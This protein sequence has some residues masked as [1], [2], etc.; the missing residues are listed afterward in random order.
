MSSTCP[1]R[2]NPNGDV[3]SELNQRAKMW[4]IRKRNVEQSIRPPAYI[5]IENENGYILPK[6][7]MTFGEIYDKFK[8]GPMLKNVTITQGGNY[9]L[10][11][12]ME[13]EIQCHDR[14]SFAT[15]EEEFLTVGMEITC[16]FGYAIGKPGYSQNI[17]MKNFMVCGYEF[18]TTDKGYWVAKFKAVSAA[19]AI[20]SLDVTVAPLEGTKGKE[21]LIDG[22]PYKVQGLSEI[23]LYH[24]QNNGKTALDSADQV[25]YEID[26]EMTKGDLA[27]F[28]LN[29]LN[30]KGGTG[31]MG[32]LGRM[33]KNVF[34]GKTQQA[35]YTLE[36][37]VNLFNRTMKG[38]YT[39]AM[40]GNRSAADKFINLE[41]KFD[42]VLSFAYYDEHILSAD[43]RGVLL[44]MYADYRFKGT[45]KNFEDN[46][47]KLIS[48]T[49]AAGSTTETING[50]KFIK[51][52]LKHILVSLD[53]I[54]EAMAAEMP[55]KSESESNS[56]R[57]VDE[58]NL[59]LNNFFNKIFSAIR[60]ASGGAISLRLS[61]HPNVHAMP[62][63]D[64]QY[65][66]YV[67][68]E[69]NGKQ[70]SMDCIVFNP[71]DGD[72]IIKGAALSSGAGGQD[73]Q[74]AMF[75]TA[76]SGEAP[77]K[78][79]GEDTSD[80]KDKYNEAIDSDNV[81]AMMKK[82]VESGYGDEH[83]HSLKEFNNTMRRGPDK[84]VNSVS[85]FPYPG[86][87]LDID[88]EGVYGI[89]PMCGVMTTHFPGSY[90][91]NDI[92]FYV[93]SVTHK[94]DAGNSS[95]DTSFETQMAYHNDVKYIRFPQLTEAEAVEYSTEA[96]GD[97]TGFGSVIIQDT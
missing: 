1:F 92:Y 10:T 5:Q 89:N 8:P 20:L 7:E 80:K 65:S 2:S 38:T 75:A 78:A 91:D 25:E 40:Q 59:K 46:M 34:D 90:V 26:D 18:N 76:K 4:S 27:I 11:I 43:P 17:N 50:V 47:K 15:I 30:R 51:Q 16:R 74:G 81:D 52:N 73:Y 21:F 13:A 32:T 79:K 84:G 70:D 14:D 72:G 86:M 68:D 62:E 64:D 29:Q 97:T 35:Y 56:A 93:K 57:K 87:T 39:T 88:I 69:N 77:R 53:T 94:F 9:G 60:D 67:F 83:L 45:G 33:A 85:Q 31:I 12:E 61:Q 54:F 3:V 42:D 48:K 55:E 71:I 23:L 19:Q 24:A 28:D 96:G 82:L 22:K 58:A 49:K 37:I 6:S 41:I 95:W 44:P 36:Y 63:V 66:L